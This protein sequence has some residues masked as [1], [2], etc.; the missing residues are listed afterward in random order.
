MVSPA[1]IYIKISTKSIHFLFSFHSS[2]FTFHWLFGGSPANNHLAVAAAQEEV[3]P[4]TG[5]FPDEVMKP[6]VKAAGLGG[7]ANDL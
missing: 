3:V 2:L 5:N 6:P 4:D 7:N 1:G